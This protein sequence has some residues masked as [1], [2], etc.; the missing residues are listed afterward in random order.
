MNTCSDCGGLV[1]EKK[2]RIVCYGCGKDYG[3]NV[4]SIPPPVAEPIPQ[5][6]I[7]PVPDVIPQSNEPEEIYDNMG[8]M[9]NTLNH[10]SYQSAETH[11]LL[12]SSNEHLAKIRTYV[13]W[14]WWILIGIPI[15]LITIAVILATAQ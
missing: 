6:A 11:K 15:I 10:L 14:F 8:E 12:M 13:G 1:A 7:E 9:R 4:K 5:P 3:E 2:D